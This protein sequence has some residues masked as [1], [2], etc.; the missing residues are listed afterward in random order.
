MEYRD[1]RTGSGGFSLVELSIVLVI[2]GLLIGGIL[3]GRALIRSAEL[4]SVTQQYEQF[5]TASYAFRN[6]YMALPGDFTQ[7][8]AF[9]GAAAT[10]GDCL[11][12]GGTGTATCNGNGN[13]AI[14]LWVNSNEVFRFWQHLSNAAMIEGIY[15][16]VQDGAQYSATTPANAPA[17]KVNTSLW[18]IQY[19]GVQTGNAMLFDGN[20]GNALE[21]GGQFA[22]YD[23]ATPILLPSEAWNIDG[24]I[25]DGKPA[26][27]KVVVRAQNGLNTCTTGADSTALTADYLL[28]ASTQECGLFFR[29]A[30]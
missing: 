19:M 27:G 6:K 13:G 8:V 10:G 5:V 28:S 1:H 4:R 18:Y 3:S 17:G 21:F 12:V 23:P 26:M 29:Q 9:W 22:D 16:G 2:L 15:S 14:D 7:A 30:L 24:K 20:Y 11:T 25:D